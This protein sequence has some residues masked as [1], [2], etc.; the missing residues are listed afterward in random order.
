VRATDGV[1]LADGEVAGP[2]GVIGSNGRP[3]LGYSM[4]SSIP[5]EPG[6]QSHRVAS[7]RLPQRPGEA[8]LDTRTVGKQ[9]FAVGSPVRVGGAGGEANPGGCRSDAIQL[10]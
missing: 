9:K 4:V 6:L 2:G 1:R 7:G 5:T 8:V 3:V 10:I